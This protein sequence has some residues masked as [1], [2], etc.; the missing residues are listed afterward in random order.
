MADPTTTTP[1]LRH[2][3]HLEDSLVDAELIHAMLEEEWPGCEISRVQTCQIL[4]AL[5]HRPLT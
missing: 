2:L 4:A 5:Q 1:N 3:L